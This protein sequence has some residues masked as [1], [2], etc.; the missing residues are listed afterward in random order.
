MVREG[1]A[2]IKTAS[3]A[4]LQEL[5]NGPREPIGPACLVE[6][7]LGAGL[8]HSEGELEMYPVRLNNQKKLDDYCLLTGNS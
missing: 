4:Q 2:E 1:R 3:G 7:Q 6:M 8:G 5:V